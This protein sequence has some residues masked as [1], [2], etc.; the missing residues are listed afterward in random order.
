[1]T[2]HCRF[3]GA[4]LE[5]LFADLGMCP[6][7]NSLIGPDRVAAMEPFYPLRAFV[8]THCFLVQSE[9]FQSPT[10]IFADDYPYFSSYS[11]SWLEHSHEYAERIVDR[12]G[13]GEDGHTVVEVGSNDGYLLQY[14]HGAGIN[15]LGVEPATNVAQEA[16][17]RGIPTLVRFF[18]VEVAEEL[19]AESAADLLIANNVLAH[20]PDVNDFV[21]GLKILLKPGGVITAEFPHLPHLVEEV[22]FDTIY[23]EHFSYL[24]FS[25][26]TRIF[27]THGLRVFDVEELETHGGSLRMYAC[28]ADDDR[29]ATERV[30]SLAERERQG[31]YLD[32]AA[33]RAFAKRVGHVKRQ[34]LTCLIEA[35]DSGS[36]I[37]GYGAPAKGT[38][39]LNYCGVGTDFLDYTV[40]KSPHKQGSYV[41]GVRIPIRAPEEI[42]RTRPDYV[43]ILPWNL[44]DEIIDELSFVRDWGG[45]FMVRDPEMTIV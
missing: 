40:D 44:K 15:V 41:P 25:T 14:F 26:A 10:G 4:A 35:K 23:H 28:H 6:I 39:F 20:T 24:S 38:T 16:I 7:A 29:E 32:L 18:S 36:S 37:A 42:R 34:A 3:C 19:A 31:G 5:H 8:C 12:L 9:E 2:P 21:A 43:L 30:G 17:L 33:Y 11:T 22:Q 13:L 1:M 27:A 45:R